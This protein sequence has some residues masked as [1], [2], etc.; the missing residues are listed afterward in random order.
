MA[1]ITALSLGKGRNKKANVS[2]DGKPA[3]K[4][5]PEVA[6]KE[7]LEI[8]QELSDSRIAALAEASRRQSCYDAALRFLGY[9]PRSE[10]EI[11]QRLYQRGFDGAS[12]KATLSQLKERDL[13]NDGDFARFWRDNRQS[14][15]P[16]SQWLISLELKQKKVPEEIIEQVVGTIDDA[17]NAYSVGKAKARS[18][19]NCDDYQSF[20]RRLGDHLKRRGF[21]YGVI[22]KTVER[23]W[24]E[25]G[26][27]E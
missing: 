14:F 10:Y 17:E 12:I 16:R 22:I 8:G 25:R 19:A 27:P 13:I 24:Q 26:L 21:G 9:R 3:L 15:S 1:K 2:L 20:R 6:L 5:E 11:K 23:L 4:L 7:G 18:L